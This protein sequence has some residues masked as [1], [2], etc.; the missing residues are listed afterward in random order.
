MRLGVFVALRRSE[1][2]P[3]FLEDIRKGPPKRHSII[4]SQ[5]G[6][7]MAD[8]GFLQRVRGKRLKHRDDFLE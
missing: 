1:G 6:R 5:D 4:F 8:I 3:Y 7:R 2:R